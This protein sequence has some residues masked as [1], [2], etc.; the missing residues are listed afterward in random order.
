MLKITISKNL[1]ALLPLA[2]TVAPVVP[3]TAAV[4]TTVTQQSGVATGVV[5]DADGQPLAGASVVVLGTKQM[6]MT[7]ESG[8]FTIK[9]VRRGATLR[10]TYIGYKTQTVKWDGQALSLVMESLDNTLNEVVVTAMGIQRKEKSLTY[11]TQKVAGSD[12]MK[13]QDANFANSLQGRVSGVTITPSAGGAGGASK[14]V[15]R[16]NKSILGNN[17]PLVV[18]DGIPMIN[19]TNGQKAWGDGQSLTYQGATE[20]SDPLSM[21]NP[22]D[23]ETINVLKGANASALYGSLAANGVLMITTKK[24]KEGRLDVTYT[25]NITFE[26][27]FVTPKIQNVYGSEFNGANPAYNSW[28]SKLA[29]QTDAQLAG[30]TAHLRR[31]GND[32]VADFF[33]TG[34]TTNNSVSLSGGTEKIKTYFSLANS[35]ADGMVPSNMYNRNNVAFRQSYELF[36]KRLNVDVSLNYT[37]TK[38]VNRQGGGTALNPIYDLY[39]MPRNV[40]MNYYRQHYA[41]EGKWE[42]LDEDIYVLRN[43]AYYWEA[44]TPQLS[45]VMQEFAYGLNTPHNNPYWLLHQNRGVQKEERLSGYVSGRLKLLEGLDLQGRI[46]V[47]LNR[48]NNVSNRWATTRLP[49]NYSSYGNYY[50][51]SYDEDEIYMDYL[52]SYT[53]QLNDDWSFSGTAGWVGHTTHGEVKTF[54][55]PATIHDP[56][57]RK[58]ATMVNFFDLTAGTYGVT[59]SHYRTANWDRA[60]LFTGQVGW[61]DMIFFDASYRQD[62]YA[63]FKQFHLTRGTSTNYGYFSFGANAILSQLIKLPKFVNYLKYRLSY[64]EVGNSIPNVIFNN[65]SSDA[66]TGAVAARPYAYFDDPKP[67]MSKSFETGVEA[68][69]FENNLNVDLTYYNSAMHNAYVLI[70]DPSGLPKPVTSGIIRNQGIEASVSYNWAFARNWQWK[71]AFNFSVNANKIVKTYTNSDGKK[72]RMTQSFAG[73]NVEVRYDE[74]GKYGDMYAKDFERNSDGTIKLNSQG[75]PSLSNDWNKMVYIGNMNSKWNLG[76]SNTVSYKD[77]QLFFLISGRIGGKVLSYT[78]AV[79][80]NL[81]TSQ[82]S[83]DARLAAEKSGLTFNGEP[84]M[85]LGDG[86]LVPVRGYYEEIGSKF[87][88]TEYVYSATNFRL[89]ELSLGYTFR[90]LLG[91]AKNL[92]VSFIARNLFFL[93]KDAPIDPD[94]ALSTQNGLNAFEVFNQPSARSYGFSLKL[95]F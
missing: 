80:D 35:H 29:E 47:N 88:P 71:T 22:D 93:Y 75:L 60:L 34:V 11:A 1:L 78:E 18:V 31:T 25:S 85:K 67:E 39:T 30:T 40:D 70:S 95:N 10:L 6:V 59:R 14:I 21:I 37:K 55:A 24:G 65:V 91:D 51:D 4:Y 62:W 72:T 9:G 36:N 84:A 77:F 2:A 20:G 26:T 38:T 54:G 7:D 76:W 61:K 79:L 33:R 86:Q 28:G 89:R 43:G 87:Y 83:A 49:K 50:N 23:I 63:A 12:L 46:S 32:D 41:T 94:V 68:G 19:N 58:V 42:G 45:G 66:V 56:L 52:L 15:L 53:K 16:G 69:F 27:P 81:G 13:V 44:V 73:G 48:T 92:S 3:V 17:S 8:R 74:G 5:K 90:N 57:R 64:S 82:R